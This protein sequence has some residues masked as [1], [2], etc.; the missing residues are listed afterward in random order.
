LNKEQE[1]QFKEWISEKWGASKLPIGGAVPFPATS[2]LFLTGD[3]ATQ[4][5]SV[6]KDKCTGCTSCYFIC[7]DDCIR[8]DDDFKPNFDLDYCKGCA[9]CARVCK[10]N[11]ITMTEVEK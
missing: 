2:K 11:A 6:D 10:E 4:T 9:L 1:A 7:P 8:L 5:P 3:W